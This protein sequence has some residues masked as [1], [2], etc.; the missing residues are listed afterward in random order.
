MI[1]CPR[2]SGAEASEH[3]LI[4]RIQTAPQ[5]AHQLLLAA[6]GAVLGRT[7][8]NGQGAGIPALGGTLHG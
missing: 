8:V 3:A 5:S 6:D 7:R 2:S 4:R 1:A